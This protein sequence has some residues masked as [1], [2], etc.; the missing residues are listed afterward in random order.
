[1]NSV[2]ASRREYPLHVNRSRVRK[3]SLKRRFQ[4]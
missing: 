3:Q 1:M 4:R 2:E